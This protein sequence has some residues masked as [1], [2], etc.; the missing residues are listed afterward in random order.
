MS[1]PILLWVNAAPTLSLTSPTNGN[2]FTGPATITVSAQV[3]DPVDG[4]ARVEFYQG[5]TLLGSRTNSPY[6]VT[7]S[8]LP[9][10]SYSFLAVATDPHGLSA[11]SAVATVTVRSAN[12]FFADLF[13][14]RGAVSETNVTVLGTN[15]AATKEANEPQINVFNAGGKSLWISW[16]APVAGPV[17]IDTFGSSFDTLLSVYTNAPGQPVTLPHLVKVAE[18][19]DA[20]GLALVQS[21]VQFTNFVA[22]QEYM[23]TVDGFDGAS[24]TVTLHISQNSWAPFIITQPANQTNNAGTTAT[25]TVVASGGGTLRYQWQFNSVS[26]PGQT[27]AMLALSNVQ[28]TNSGSYSVVVSSGYGSVASTP[29]SLLVRGP[30]ILVQPQG[31]TFLAGRAAALSVGATGSS[32]TYQ[33]RQNGTNLPGATGAGYA[34]NSVQPGQAGAYTVLVSDSF[35][36]VLSQPAVVF[37]A[38]S[39]PVLSSLTRAA[40][41]ATFQVTA[42]TTGD[43]C[44]VDFSLDLLSWTNLTILT[45]LSGSFPVTDPAP[46]PKTRFYRA[47]LAP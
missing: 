37:V 30:I 18:N 17:S 23:I 40:S 26:L 25:F 34:I 1:A 44:Y 27:N 45:N 32:L 33:W 3:A 16:I 31:G 7:A 4:V 35:G 36:S 22:G 38:V 39:Q 10:G 43:K 46:G 24:G 20:P 9:Y 29:A 5:T 47:H 14:N 28:T 12:P 21:Q 42:T 11:T 19:D 6:S 2:S 41:T 13:A 8:N 15:T